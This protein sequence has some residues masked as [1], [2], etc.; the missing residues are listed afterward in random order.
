MSGLNSPQSGRWRQRREPP[1]NGRLKEAMNLQV[2]SPRKML[3]SNAL[4]LI[5]GS[6]EFFNGPSRD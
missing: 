5:V 1:K 4:C 2:S 6:G 3:H